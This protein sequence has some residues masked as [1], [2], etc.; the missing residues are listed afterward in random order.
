MKLGQGDYQ[1]RV[2]DPWGQVAKRNGLRTSGDFS[3]I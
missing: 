1:D 3:V 2:V